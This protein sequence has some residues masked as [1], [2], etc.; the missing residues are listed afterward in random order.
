MFDKGAVLDNRYWERGLVPV[1]FC[2]DLFDLQVCLFAQ[3]AF[4]DHGM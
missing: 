3:S 4:G 2:D 1:D